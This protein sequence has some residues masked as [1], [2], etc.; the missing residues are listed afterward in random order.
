M[1][2]EFAAT[3][4]LEMV[5][6]CLDGDSEE[7]FRLV[8]AALVTSPGSVL[9]ALAGVAAQAVSGMDGAPDELVADLLSGFEVA[10]SGK[11]G[12]LRLVEDVVGG[13]G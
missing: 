6:A 5:K 2:A 1:S 4:A 7:L 8:D 13:E 9:V 10:L 12:H 3:H 11:P